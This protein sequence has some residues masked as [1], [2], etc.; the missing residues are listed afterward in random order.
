MLGLGT[1]LWASLGENVPAVCHGRVG[2]EASSVEHP[3]AFHMK[4]ES[5]G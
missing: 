3:P 5:I 2:I 4:A 1:E